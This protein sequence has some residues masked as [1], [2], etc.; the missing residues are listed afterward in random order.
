[1]GID[2]S[3]TLMMN[4]YAYAS[5]KI[6]LELLD[7]EEAKIKNKLSLNGSEKTSD[8]A[9]DGLAESISH[10]FFSWKKRPWKR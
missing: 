3:G 4:E 5:L 8:R 9:L 1:M 6:D 2:W 10:Q 7:F